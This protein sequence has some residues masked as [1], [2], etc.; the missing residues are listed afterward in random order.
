MTQTETRR[1]LPGELL[2]RKRVLY[3]ELRHRALWLVRA[4]WWAPPGMA[5]SLLL[6]SWLRIQVPIGPLLAV[7]VA[8]LGYNA[9]FRLRYRDLAGRPPLEVET[10]LRRFTRW[11]V[12]CD[13]LAMFALLHLTGGAASPFLPFFLFHVIFA[14]LLLR[15][16]VAFGFAALAAA[17]VGTLGLAEQL[18]WLP[19]RPLLHDGSPLIALSGPMPLLVVWGVFAFALLIVTL[20]TTRIVDMVRRRIHDLADLGE[21][22]IIL[23]DKLASLHR[24]M[25]G[26]VSLHRLEPVLDLV[27]GELPAVMRIQGLSVKLLEDD[28][29]TLRFA[30]AGGLPG[31]LREG[32][33]VDLELSPLNRRIIEGEPYV[34]GSLTRR[35]QFQL[36]ED[37]S[38]ASIRSVLFVPLRLEERVIGILGAYCREADRFDRNDVEF[39][40]L[41]SELVAIAIENARAY[42]AIEELGRQRERFMLRVTHNLRAPLAAVLSMLQV[43]RGGYLGRLEPRQEEYLRRIDRRSR[44]LADLINELLVLAESQGERRKLERA[45]VEVGELVA[46]AGRTFQDEAAD[47]GLRLDVSAAAGLPPVRGDEALLDRLLENL[48]SNALKYTPSGGGVSLR[49]EDGTAARPG[50]VRLIVADTGIGIPPA[51]RPR[52]FSE[53]FRAENAREVEEAGTGL[54]L[55]IA[56]EI[57]QQHRGEIEVASEP[58]RGTTFTV[59]LPAGER[60]P[61]GSESH[62]NDSDVVG[63]A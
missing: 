11:Q 56:R 25:H 12:T 33:T 13:Y 39:L 35:D 28:G 5:A 62:A 59:V 40:Q 42:E 26:L 3:G 31:R 22:V 61:E 41:A 57:V 47:R 6:A 19:W 58:G 20:I 4:R 9:L 18:G 29:R 45:P 17:G 10:D 34:T 37:L 27:C 23:N 32:A 38:A 52:L 2:Q 15:R 36:G 46:R 30:A 16:R 51:D 55:V 1:D 48:V 14:S 8:I 7:A 44:G 53:F 54:G 24:I 49:A 43:V 60:P 50:T 21:R 63:S